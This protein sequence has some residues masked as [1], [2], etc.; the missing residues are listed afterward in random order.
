MFFLRVMARQVPPLAKS[1]ASR[2]TS[3]KRAVSRYVE[4]RIRL[5]SLLLAVVIII[6]AAL[7]RREFCTKRHGLQRFSTSHVARCQHAVVMPW[8][9]LFVEFSSPLFLFFK[10]E[11]IRTSNFES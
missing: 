1:S 6:A 7:A 5:I 8:S 11:I 3:S 9:I 10:L 2:I 4:G